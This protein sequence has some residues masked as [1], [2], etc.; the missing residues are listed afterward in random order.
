VTLFREIFRQ[1]SLSTQNFW[2][3]TEKLYTAAFTEFYNFKSGDRDLSDI[4]LQEEI[5]IGSM[6]FFN[7]F[8]SAYILSAIMN[9]PMTLYQGAHQYIKNGYDYY[10]RNQTNRLEA[11][12]VDNEEDRPLNGVTLRRRALPFRGRLE[13]MASY[14]KP[15]VALLHSAILLPEDIRRPHPVAMR[16][17]ALPE[18]PRVKPVAIR[19]QVSILDAQSKP[20]L[21]GTEKRRTD[22]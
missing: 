14:P 20:S 12:V 15:D 16:E 6:C 11:P 5:N 19:C 17:S 7:Y 10:I 8:D 13:K 9:L 22:G 18:R 4:T 1:Y 2:F 21:P 3:A